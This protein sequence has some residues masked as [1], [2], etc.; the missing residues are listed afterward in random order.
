MFTDEPKNQL[1]SQQQKNFEFEYMINPASQ[2][3]RN[4]QVAFERICG[5]HVKSATS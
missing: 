4:L 5:R 1:L 3:L 2:M